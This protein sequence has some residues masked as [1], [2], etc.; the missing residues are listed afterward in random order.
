MLRVCKSRSTSWINESKLKVPTFAWQ[1][2][3]SVFSVSASALERVVRYVETQEAHH[4][5]LTFKEELLELLQ[6]HGV[7]YDERFLW[8]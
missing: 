2:G 3:Y 4:R 5:K 8:D 7:E 6:K 1:T